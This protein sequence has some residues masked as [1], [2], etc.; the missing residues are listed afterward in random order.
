M[1]KKKPLEK[2]MA[3]FEEHGFTKETERLAEAKGVNKAMLTAY[4]GNGW[5]NVSVARDGNIFFSDVSVSIADLKQTLK[6]VQAEFINGEIFHGL[7]Y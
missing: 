4:I 3:L 5:V 2:I 7:D 6:K 1:I